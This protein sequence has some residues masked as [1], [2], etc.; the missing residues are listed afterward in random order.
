MSLTLRRYEVKAF[1][2]DG[3]VMNTYNFE[4][5]GGANKAESKLNEV[6]R[7]GRRA[8]LKR[9]AFRDGKWVEE[10]NVT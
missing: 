10:A 7:A 5:R 9:E 4:G 3:K 8:V 6:R 1:G 2:N